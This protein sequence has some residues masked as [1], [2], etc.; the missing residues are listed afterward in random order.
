MDNVATGDLYG[1]DINQQYA[2]VDVTVNIAEAPQN[3]TALPTSYCRHVA[4]PQPAFSGMASADL[5]AVVAK[6]SHITD[7]NLTTRLPR[8]W[9]PMGHV[10]ALLEASMQQR[11]FEV[12]ILPLYSTASA[13]GAQYIFPH[14]PTPNDTAFQLILNVR[15]SRPPS[16]Q[17]AFHVHP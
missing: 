8:S 4:S 2:A 12:Q 6:V 16:C 3:R 1:F 10:T 13:S 7:A 11:G 5:L 14:L 15:Y 9:L 17:D